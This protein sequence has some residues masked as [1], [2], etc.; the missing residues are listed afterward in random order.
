MHHI[1]GK[2]AGKPSDYKKC[3]ICHAINWYEN[4]TCINCNHHLLLTLEFSKKDAEQ[5]LQ[6]FIED[7]YLKDEIELD[8]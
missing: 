2:I 1:I 7:G 4:L 8:V 6:D 3:P 5:F